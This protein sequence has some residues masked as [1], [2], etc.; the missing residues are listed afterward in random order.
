MNNDFVKKSYNKIAENYLSTRDQFKNNKYLEKLNKLLKQVS[1]ILDL[2]CGAGKP[3]DE[4]FV[5][6]GHKVIGLDISEKQIELAK[7]NLPN[8]E[9]KV[10][11]MSELTN[12][13]YLVDAVISFYAIFHIKRESHQELFNKINSFL[14]VGGLILVSMGSSNWEGTESDFHGIE[15]FWSHF[16]ADKN[17]EIIKNAGF[18]ILLD[19]I[20]TS[21]NEKHLIVI[22][23]KL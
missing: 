5:K 16:D 1:L 9:F 22:A 14:P 2:G 12:S 17:K 15:M 21:N 7:K 3:V 23:Q 6:H 10:E 4:F 8:G 11:D 19:E 13:E 18:K 20:D